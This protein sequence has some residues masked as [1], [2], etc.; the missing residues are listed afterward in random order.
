MVNS[1]T[2][3]KQMA[4]KKFSINLYIRIQASLPIQNTKEKE[5]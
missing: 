3:V 1:P 5:L 2:T 4:L